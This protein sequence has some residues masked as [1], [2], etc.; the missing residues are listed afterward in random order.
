[1]LALD[2]VYVDD[3]HAYQHVKE[4][5]AGAHLLYLLYWIFWYKRTRLLLRKYEYTQLRSWGEGSTRPHRFT[6]FTGIKDLLLTPEELGRELD[7]AASPKTLIL[8]HDLMYSSHPYYHE[9]NRG[10]DQVCN[11]GSCTKV[12]CP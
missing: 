9:D 2:L 11:L 10:E 1:M 5:L 7:K 8:L 12:R 3:W 4:E 6:C